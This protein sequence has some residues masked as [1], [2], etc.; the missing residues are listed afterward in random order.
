MEPIT[1]AT[2]SAALSGIKTLSDIAKAISDT[3]LR[4]EFSAQIADLQGVLIDA[5]QQMLEIQDR[6]E[7]LLREN[8]QLKEAAAPRDR[9]T[10]FYGCYKFEG[11][12]RLYCPGCYDS[13][14]KKYVTSR[15][16][17]RFRQCTVCRVE[18]GSG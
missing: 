17:S 7:A 5:R 10:L 4:H 15:L 9:P 6:Y 1:L 13:K 18:I 3:K 14:G 2:L 16:N 12:D 11:D 8:K